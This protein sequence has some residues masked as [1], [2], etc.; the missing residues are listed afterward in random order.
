MN[1]HPFSDYIIC[2][3]NFFE[4]P[5]QVY[6]LSTRQEYHR[7]S[8]YPG[9]RTNNLFESTDD[10]TKEFAKYFANK[11]KYEIFPG[12]SHFM[13]DARFHINDVFDHDTANL[14]WIHTDNTHLAG[15]VYLTPNE[16]DFSSG[17]S[18]FNKITPTD[19]ATNDFISRQ[20]FNLK[21]EVSQE[22][23]QDLK[24]N[25]NNFDETIKV[26]NQFNRLVAYDAMIYHRPNTY[27]TKSGLPRVALV[28]FIQGYRFTPIGNEHGNH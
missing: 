6:E 27:V 8:V 7:S 21:K 11:L 9:N 20:E 1:R 18:L 4:N 12:I 19:F 5:R 23:I 22:Y 13:I 3:N 10:N 15:L 25:W 28:F 2:K 17:T 14:G 26:G 16:S 24:N